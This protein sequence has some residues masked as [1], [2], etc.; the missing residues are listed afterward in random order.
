MNPTIESTLPPRA[1]VLKTGKVLDEKN[2]DSLMSRVR[3]LTGNGLEMVI[4]DCSNLEYITSFGLAVFLRTRKILRR[5]HGDAENTTSSDISENHRVR[6]TN[7][8][9]HV[10]DVLRT[11][12]L[13]DILP[14]FDDV[15]AAAG[16][17]S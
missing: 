16:Q 5:K 4:F 14:V 11:A 9:P 12:R 3:D 1:A 17:P 10:I 13:L 15:H 7:V 6:L 2:A 8:A